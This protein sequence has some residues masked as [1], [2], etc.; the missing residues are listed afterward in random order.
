M[1]QSAAAAVAMG[2]ASPWAN[3]QTWETTT[4]GRGLT[5]EGEYLLCATLARGRIN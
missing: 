4:K 5:W 2:V 3:A 1:R